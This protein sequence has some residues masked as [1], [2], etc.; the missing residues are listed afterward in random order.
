MVKVFDDDIQDVRFRASLPDG[1]RTN[2]QV[3]NL[4]ETNGDRTTWT[5]D[6]DT[7]T[8][9]GIY[10]YQIEMR[11]L[12]GNI[13]RFPDITESPTPSPTPRGTEPSISPTPR[14]TRQPSAGGFV[15]EA[16]YDAIEADIQ[17]LSDAFGNNVDRAQ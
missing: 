4:F 2:F 14:P 3:G 10:G 12:S 6:L 11:D 1:T 17:A 8:Q 9:K 15:T 7:S 16:E 5:F 13:V